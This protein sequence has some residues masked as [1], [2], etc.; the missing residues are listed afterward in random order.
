MQQLYVN[1]LSTRKPDTISRLVGCESMDRH[2]QQFEQF[3]GSFKNILHFWFRTSLRLF[4]TVLCKYCYK[5]QGLGLGLGPQHQGLE[6]LYKVLTTTLFISRKRS[7]CVKYVTTTATYQHGSACSVQA[8]MQSACSSVHAARQRPC[9]SLLV[10]TS[11]SGRSRDPAVCGRRVVL[12]A[13]AGL[14]ETFV[15]TKPTDHSVSQSVN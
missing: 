5:C 8:C 7:E 12:A 15:A 1:V 4:P 2:G 13:A 6:F 9:T 11:F 3:V 10:M 14:V